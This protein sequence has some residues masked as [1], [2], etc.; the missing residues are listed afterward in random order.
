MWF[1]SEYFVGNIFKQVRAHLFAQINGF[2][3]SK[4]PNSSIW[5]LD[6]TLTGTTT[7]GP[8][9]TRSN[10]SQ[11]VFHIP[12]SS[13]TGASP[14]DGLVSYLGHLLS[15]VLLLYRDAVSIQPGDPARSK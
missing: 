4:G 9:G 6:G 13:T 15:R 8:R 2:K 11:G 14:W 5:P 1:V 12:Q 10:D 7:L 3:Y